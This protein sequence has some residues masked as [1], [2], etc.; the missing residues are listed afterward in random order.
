MRVRCACDGTAFTCSKVGDP[1]PVCTAAPGM[2]L[3]TGDA[4]T[5]IGRCAGAGGGNVCVCTGTKVTCD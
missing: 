4:C 5:G 2:A 3:A 1:M